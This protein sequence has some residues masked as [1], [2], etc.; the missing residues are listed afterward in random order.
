MCICSRPWT[1][2]EC[3]MNA[4]VC[5]AAETPR[6]SEWYEMPYVPAATRP[7]CLDEEKRRL[8]M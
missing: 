4:C 1:R 8:E 6:S 7:R 2:I 3:F 5:A